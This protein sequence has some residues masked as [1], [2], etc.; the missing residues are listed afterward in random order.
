MYLVL[1]IILLESQ[2]LLVITLYL[3]GYEYTSTCLK[4]YWKEALNE[5]SLTNGW[6]SVARRAQQFTGL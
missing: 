2:E 3:V 5:L 1:E 6:Q 4:A